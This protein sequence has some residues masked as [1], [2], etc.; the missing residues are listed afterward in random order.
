MAGGGDHKPCEAAYLAALDQERGE[1]A[2][3]PKVTV[4]ALYVKFQ[5]QCEF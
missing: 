4:L 5:Q 2:L 1:D 3:P